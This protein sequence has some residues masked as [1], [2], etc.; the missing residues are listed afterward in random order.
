VQADILNSLIDNTVLLQITGTRHGLPGTEVQ[1]D[2]ADETSSGLLNVCYANGMNILTI[3]QDLIDQVIG[4][5][6][7][8]AMQKIDDCIRAAL[9]LR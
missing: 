2:P 1:L 3:D 7:A 9:E 4:S 6:S 5:L 8:V